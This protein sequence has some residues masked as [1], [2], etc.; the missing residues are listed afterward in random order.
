M[1]SQQ[2]PRK[3]PLADITTSSTRL[4]DRAANLNPVNHSLR[5]SS[6]SLS[7]ANACDEN[8][9]TRGILDM[10]L[11]AQGGGSLARKRSFKPMNDENTDPRVPPSHSL[12]QTKPFP[13]APA[14][15]RK[16][17]LLQSVVAVPPPVAPRKSLN[18]LSTLVQRQVIGA[19]KLRPRTV[20]TRFRLKDFVSSEQD[21]YRFVSQ[22]ETTL[23]PPFSCKFNNAAIGGRYLAIGD[24]DGT[25]H[26]VDTRKEESHPALTRQLLAHKNAI[27]DLA[28]TNDD[29]KITGLVWDEGLWNISA[30]GDQTAKLH[31]IETRTCI[32][33]FSGHNGSIKSVSLKPSDNSTTSTTGETTYRPSDRL[34]NVHATKS[35]QS[36][37]KKLKHGADGPNTASA[38]QYMIHND[39]ILAS[40]GSL[41]GCIKYWDVRKHGSYFK[42][43]YPT[44]LQTSTYIPRTKR[45]HGLAAMTLSPDGVSLYAVS[46]D[47]HM[48]MYNATTLGAPLRHFTGENFACSSYYIKIAVSPDGQYV[49]S[50]SSKNLYVWDVDR[51]QAKPLIFHGHERE[52]TGVDWS[53]DLGDGTQWL[54]G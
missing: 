29:S 28:W 46:S 26:I 20:T 39:N 10:F 42:V 52:V 12:S 25:I 36:P 2:A 37:P 24:E 33:A 3:A 31:D 43:D 18:L 41:D 32:G 11:I 9:P 16:D 1:P 7:S 15:S 14:R 45:A 23:V 54:F 51:P 53:K 17:T 22:D 19:K 5:A 47:N 50:G 40:T 8:T 13:T 49:A 35:R 38:V 21:V 30:S 34:L 48:Y 4:R 6:S 44:P 27:F